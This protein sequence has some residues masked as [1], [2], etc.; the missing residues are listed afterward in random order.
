[1]TRAVAR[2]TPSSRVV[3]KYPLTYHRCGTTGVL[4]GATVEM[5][6]RIGSEG[7]LS[8]IGR[9][10]RTL[11]ELAESEGEYGAAPTSPGNPA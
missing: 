2:G 3:H 4:S 6:E 8:I 1:M 5:F 10:P 11:R 7:T 9:W